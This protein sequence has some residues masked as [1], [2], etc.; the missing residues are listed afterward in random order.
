MIM[1][2]VKR[3][4]RNLRMT[5][6]DYKKA[7]N[8]VPHSW[9]LRSMGLV[10]VATNITSFMEKAVKMWNTTLTINGETIGEVKIKRGIFQGDSLSPLLFII[11]LIPLTI[12]LRAMNKGYKLDDIKVNHLLCTWTTLRSMHV[13]TRKWN[14]LLT[15]L[16]SSLR[17]FPW[18]LGLKNVPKYQSIK[19]NW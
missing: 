16:E 18:Y 12:T 19:E 14:P 2:H 6:I 9:I 11:S 13:L 10:G 5:W 15:P 8:S 17:T 1:K 3:K 4:Q 7:Y